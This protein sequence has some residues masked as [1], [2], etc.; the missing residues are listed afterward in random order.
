MVKQEEEDKKKRG[1]ERREACLLVCHQHHFQTWKENKNFCQFNPLNP[2]I[3]LTH[4]S[5]SSCFLPISGLRIKRYRST[6]WVNKGEG[7]G[8][9]CDMLEEEEIEMIRRRLTVVL[10][11]PVKWPADQ[12]WPFLLSTTE[13]HWLKG[14]VQD[15]TWSDVSWRTSLPGCPWTRTPTAHQ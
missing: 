11:E 7:K 6:A 13:F 15:Y 3:A 1:C 9:G 4:P 14:D 12:F 10:W 8:N 2:V 5:V